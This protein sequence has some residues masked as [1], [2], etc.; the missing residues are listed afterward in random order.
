[1]TLPPRPTAGPL[2]DRP[3]D[4]RF[5]SK[6]P[7]PSRHSASTRL[8]QAATFAVDVDGRVLQWSSAAAELFGLPPEQALGRYAACLL[9]TPDAHRH[10]SEVLA[11]VATGRRWNGVLRVAPAAGVCGEDR[12]IEFCWDPAAGPAGPLVAV[13]AHS[14]VAA[15]VAGG[16]SL[17]GDQERFALLNEAS[18]RIGSTLDL[19]RT[20]AELM[21]VAVP[22]FADAAGI[23]VRDR[24]VTHNEFPEHS[25]DGT[26][27]V[28]RLAIGVAD[29]NPEE[30]AAAFPI[31]EITV[32]PAWTPYARCMA[33]GETILF[34]RMDTATAEDIGRR[35]KK[36]EIVVQLLDHTSFLL[37]PLMARGRGLGFVVFTRRRDSL[38]FDEEDVALAEELAARAAMCID[39]ARLFNREHRTALTL[40]SSLL[41]RTLAAPLGMEVVHRYLP[42][43]DLTGVGGDWYD[44]IPLPGCRTALVVG[45]VMGHGTSAAATMGQ[46]RTAVRTLAAL[47]LPPDEVLYRLDQMARDVDD[48][49][50]ATCVYATY[51]PV[52]RHCVIARAGHVPPILALSDG[53]AGV[54]ELPPGLPLGIGGEPFGVRELT[55]PD[56]ATLALYT[57][58]LVESRERDIDTGLDALQAQL[59]RPYDCLEEIGTA[60][61]EALRPGSDR[62]DIA[63]LLARVQAL[64]DEH[65]ADVTL[66]AEPAAVRPARRVVRTTLTRWRLEPL[67][68]TAELLVSELVTNAIRHASGPVGLRLLRGG[69]ALMCEVAD[70]SPVLPRL[71]TL[72]PD[73]LDI[74]GRGVQLVNVLAQRWGT[75]PTPEGKIVW[76][77]IP[78]PCTTSMFRHNPHPG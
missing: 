20:A 37:V 55:L 66:P 45:D 78:I 39:N 36:R 6:S 77:E 75:R 62:D 59:A 46:L 74:T 61:I 33:T 51:D 43:S 40:Q 35:V 42:A 29:E 22:R 64:T 56:G 47:D 41:P 50:T 70:E 26:A 76:C 49:V 53:T 38:E 65:I 4:S 68:D 18:A 67:I 13:C 32:Y 1:M 2:D 23:L 60:A 25:T 8:T 16:S 31:G 11:H 5:V 58:G 21:D 15:L 69:Q 27:V 34:D 17:I 63:L 48:T 57:D 54:V 9:G 10:V 44:V 52:S 72:D 12:R 7:A 3:A 71:R 73:A 28:R 19:D 14:P 30:W 24:L